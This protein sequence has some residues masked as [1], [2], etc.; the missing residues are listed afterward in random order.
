MSKSIENRIQKV[1]L[2]QSSINS[3]LEQYAQRKGAS[4]IRTTP[5]MSRVQIVKPY[6]W[7]QTT[8]PVVVQ[9]P[10]TEI[11]QELDS[12]VSLE[13]GGKATW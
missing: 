9:T 3:A 7:P 1:R 6:A 8:N 4:L 2:R 10:D 12:P 13:R 11:A 5:E